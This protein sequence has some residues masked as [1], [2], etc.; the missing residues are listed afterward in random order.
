MNHSQ[1]LTGQIPFHYIRTDSVVIGMVA[2]GRRP[3]RKKSQIPAEAE[4][5]WSILE[6]CWAK[7]MEARPTM[8]DVVGR[9]S[10]L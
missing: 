7:E 6:A 9:L 8:D 3:D 2:G 4:P 5:L 1:V 10:I